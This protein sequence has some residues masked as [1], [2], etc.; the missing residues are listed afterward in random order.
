MKI[1]Q[2][3][4]DFAAKHNAASFLAVHEA[5]QGMA[6]MNERFRERGGEIYLPASS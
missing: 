4:R 3:V 5:E 2:Q 6:E 1:I